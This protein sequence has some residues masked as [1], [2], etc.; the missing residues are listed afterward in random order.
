MAVTSPVTPAIMFIVGYVA[1]IIMNRLVDEL[2]E[3]V[4]NKEKMLGTTAPTEW[5]KNE[6]CEKDKQRLWEEKEKIEIRELDEAI[7]CLERNGF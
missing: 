3:R 5:F 7:K 2:K 4:A 1:L 6:R